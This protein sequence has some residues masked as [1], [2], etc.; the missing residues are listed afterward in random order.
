VETDP[1]GKRISAGWT[2]TPDDWPTWTPEGVPW[3]H[4]KS[5]QAKRATCTWQGDFAHHTI[6]W[7]CRDCRMRIT[8]E[9]LIDVGTPTP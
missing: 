3:H 5:M 7:H 9:G 4:N 1:A 8:V 2:T 6:T